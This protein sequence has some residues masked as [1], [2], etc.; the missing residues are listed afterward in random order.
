VAGYGVQAGLPVE[1]G[2]FVTHMKDYPAR[3]AAEADASF[4]ADEDH[5][6]EPGELVLGR[7]PRPE[8]PQDVEGSEQSMGRFGLRFGRRGTRP[9]AADVNNVIHALRLPAYA[10]RY[11]RARGPGMPAPA[12][13]PRILDSRTDRPDVLGHARG[14]CE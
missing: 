14:G 3:G 9:G 11:A 7:L 12:A 5:R 6:I 4:P 1:G 2:A 13:G 8:E 10:G